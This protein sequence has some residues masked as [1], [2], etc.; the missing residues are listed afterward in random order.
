MILKSDRET[1]KD[2]T[3]EKQEKE[4]QPTIILKTREQSTPKE[5]R[6]QSPKIIKTS[7]CES[8][9]QPSKIAHNENKEKKNIGIYFVCTNNISSQYRYHHQQSTAGHKA[10]H[11]TWAAAIGI[12]YINNLDEEKTRLLTGPFLTYIA[13][14]VLEQLLYVLLPLLLWAKYK[15]ITF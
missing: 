1:V 5:E 9:G 12:H 14:V 3:K 2:Q 15:F 6:P 11:R 13:I 7:T 4:K 8:E 10:G